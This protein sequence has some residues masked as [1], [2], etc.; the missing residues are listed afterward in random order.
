MANDRNAGRPKGERS[1]KTYWT[2]TKT[3]ATIKQI[4]EARK[5]RKITDDDLERLTNGII[6]KK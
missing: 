3:H 5:I 1:Q 4:V 6:G 2:D